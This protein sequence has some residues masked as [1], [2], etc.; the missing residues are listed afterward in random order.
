MAEHDD[1]DA[2]LD[3]LCRERA[4]L[5]DRERAD[6]EVELRRGGDL[7][8]LGL[9]PAGRQG[10]AGV[11][12]PGREHRDRDAAR[13]GLRVLVGHAGAAHPGSPHRVGHVAELDV[14]ELPQAKG[15]HAEQRARELV[16]HVAV[17][18]FDDRYHGDE[19]HHAD[20]DADDREAAL[21]LL[22]P[23]GLEGEANG[24]EK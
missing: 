20:E 12:F 3:F 19:E 4:A 1:R 10:R 5:L 9:Q 21:E 23:N 22:R 13:D 14:G 7:H 17:H 16:G 24:V 2:C 18:A 8:V 11:R 15:V 6:V